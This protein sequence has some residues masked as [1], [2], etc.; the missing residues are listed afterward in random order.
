VPAPA[1]DA[2][3]RG[4]RPAAVS[5]YAAGFTT[6]FGAHSI[7]ANLGGYTGARHEPLLV[8]GVLLAVYDGAEVALKPVFGALADRVGPRPVLL[9]GLAA[10]AVF[11]AAFALAGDPALVGV[12]RFGQGAA[13]AAFSPAAGALVAGLNPAARQGRA[14][15]GYG[16][17]KSLGYAAGPLLGGVLVTAGGLRLLFAVLAVLA[18]VVAVGAAVV[19]PPVTVQPRARQTVLDLARRLAGRE[20]LAPVA[21]LAGATAALSAGVGFLPVRGAAGGLGPVATGAAVSLLAVASAVMQPLAGRARDAGRLP[22]AGGMAAGLVLAGAGLACAALL[23]GLA[24]LLPAA[25]LAGSGIGV[26][27]PLGFAALAASAPPGRLG[28]TMGAAEVG[29]ELGDAGGPL[30]V[31]AAASAAALPDGLLALAGLLAVAGAAVSLPARA[32]RDKP[33]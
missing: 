17:Y 30:L 28:Q 31:A 3:A 6:A 25:L 14:F 9:G 18:A 4:R 15:G 32:R 2:A 21:C 5:L 12:A 19:V 33:G 22:G 10:F 24:G 7:A 16:L 13:A 8:L 26:V 11:S 20:F 27:T 1:A 29:R 23:P